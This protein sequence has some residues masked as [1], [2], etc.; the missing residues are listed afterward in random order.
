MDKT[1]YPPFANYSSWADS[2]QIFISATTFGPGSEDVAFRFRNFYLHLDARKK[3][4]KSKYSNLKNPKYMGLSKD[5][6]KNFVYDAKRLL[7]QNGF[8]NMM[9]TSQYILMFDVWDTKAFFGSNLSPQEI[10]KATRLFMPEILVD[11]ESGSG[12]D[13]EEFHQ[14]LLGILGPDK[15]EKFLVA[16]D[17]VFGRSSQIP[18]NERPSV[19]DVR[20]LL[21]LESVYEAEFQKLKFNDELEMLHPRPETSELIAN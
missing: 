2:T 18:V 14:G 5:L 6:L 8:D 17:P 19:Q 16:E 7:G 15:Y 11:S 21:E 9:V 1:D 20:A 12:L 3:D 4:L 10:Y 13:S